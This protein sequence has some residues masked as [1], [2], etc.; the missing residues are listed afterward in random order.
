M[1]G[2]PRPQPG[3]TTACATRPRAGR[4]LQGFRPRCARTAS[5]LRPSR[6]YARSRRAYPRSE[7][8]FFFTA[9]SRACTIGCLQVITHR[10]RVRAARCDCARRSQITN[11][12]SSSLRMNQKLRVPS[13]KEPPL[14]FVV[15]GA[16]QLYDVWR[17]GTKGSSIQEFGISR[18]SASFTTTSH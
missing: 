16:A 15:G 5:G 18:P 14:L 6:P 11:R 13:R 3:T 2:V 9:R 12:W 17:L 4:V 8:R 10:L 7:E 1:L